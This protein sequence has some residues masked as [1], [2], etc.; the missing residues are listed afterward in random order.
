MLCFLSQAGASINRWNSID[1]MLTLSNDPMRN[2]NGT[3]VLDPYFEQEFRDFSPNPEEICA[4]EEHQAAL[5]QAIAELRPSLRNV[6]ELYQLQECSMDETAKILGIS[7]AA[8]NARL[9]H[10]R[11][12]L[13]GNKALLL[14]H[15]ASRHVSRKRFSCAM[16]CTAPF[17]Q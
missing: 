4:K 14:N 8:A 12:S 10:A 1:E 11:A 6:V 13:R 9:F 2:R 17:A 7:V 5:R 16:S 15:K 3:E